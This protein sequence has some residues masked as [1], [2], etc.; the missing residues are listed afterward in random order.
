MASEN[1]VTK[2]VVR[3]LQERKWIAKRRNVGLFYT[4]DGR[5][6]RIG[7]PGEPDWFFVHRQHGHLEIEMKKPGEK[8]DQRQQ[9]YLATM[10]ALGVPATWTDDPAKFERWYAETYKAI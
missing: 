7:T 2:A 3:F 5:P 1:E 4:R 6:V 8:P 10:N 9:E